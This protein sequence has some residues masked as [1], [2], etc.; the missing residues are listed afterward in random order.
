MRNMKTY[1]IPA[2]IILAQ[3]NLETGAGNRGSNVVYDRANSAI[4]TVT[5]GEFN[6]EQIFEGK[7][8]FLR[9]FITLFILKV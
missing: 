1:G 9:I 2:S 5:P 8:A 4:A 3:G 7:S 6:W